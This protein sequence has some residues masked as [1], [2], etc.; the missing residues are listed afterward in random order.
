MSWSEVR[1]SWPASRRTSGLWL[2]SRPRGPGVGPFDQGPGPAPTG[3]RRFRFF[4]LHR[5]R[6]HRAASGTAGPGSGEPRPLLQGTRTV[7]M[8]PR[9]EPLPSLSRG[10]L[11][12]GPHR[13]TTDQSL[14]ECLAYRSRLTQSGDEVCEAGRDGPRDIRREVP[15]EST[16]AGSSATLRLRSGECA[17][18]IPRRPAP[19]PT[20]RWQAPGR[21]PPVP[22]SDGR[23][24]RVHRC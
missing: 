21:S 6:N 2:W 19:R 14:P 24:S 10:A 15:G 16:V 17:G 3:G 9:R 4:H 12:G 11:A 7:R 20:L 1:R 8:Q 23:C 22:P 18:K 5:G 13:T